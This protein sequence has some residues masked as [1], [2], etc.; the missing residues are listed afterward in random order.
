M[1]C[2]VFQMSSRHRHDLRYETYEIA[3]RKQLRNLNTIG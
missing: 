2:S 1:G 3:L